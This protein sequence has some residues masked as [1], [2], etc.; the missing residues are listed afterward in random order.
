MKKTLTLLM[1]S[2]TL[3]GALALPALSAAHAGITMPGACSAGICASE[4]GN[5]ANESLFILVSNDDDGGDDSD[6]HD[7][8]SHD[9]DHGSSGHDDSSDNDSNDDGDSNSNS[10][11]NDS[12]DD[13]DN[14]NGND[15]CNN[16]SSGD[17]DIGNAK[18]A[19]KGPIVPPANGLFGKGAPPVAVTK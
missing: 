6:S 1:V 17:C 7:R 15:D 8:D 18:A 3:A 2:S 4:V 9:S 5:A 13:A 11:S 12:D 19:R 10:N 16:K 14:G